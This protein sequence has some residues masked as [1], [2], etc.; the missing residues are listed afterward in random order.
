I[1]SNIIKTKTDSKTQS[2]PLRPDSDF[3]AAGYLPE[4]LELELDKLG[5]HKEA[6]G[7]KYYFEIPTNSNDISNQLQ[8]M[9]LEQILGRGDILEKLQLLYKVGRINIRCLFE[10]PGY[11]TNSIGTSDA[12]PR[13]CVAWP[14]RETLIFDFAGMPKDYGAACLLGMLVNAK[15]DQTGGEKHF[16]KPQIDGYA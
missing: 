1:F 8:K 4:K 12:I 2:L 9:L 11:V 14:F 13:L 3:H 5:L 6:K 16:D 7:N 15:S 10:N